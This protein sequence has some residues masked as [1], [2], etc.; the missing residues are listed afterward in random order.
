[1]L[2]TQLGP[3]ASK[4]SS[5]VKRCRLGA[6][7]AKTGS[8]S[9]L[10]GRRG[11]VPALFRAAATRL[12][13][14]SRGPPPR[15]DRGPGRCEPPTNFGARSA[16]RGD[17]RLCRGR[18]GFRTMSSQGD[19]GS[20]SHDLLVV[21][22][23]VLGRLIAARWREVSV[24]VLASVAAEGAQPARERPPVLDCLTFRCPSHLPGAPGIQDR[25]RDGVAPQPRR[26]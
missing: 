11:S 7:M 19:A 24:C 25:G 9:V 3:K 5:P 23:G 22:P 16:L 17:A 26:P 1:M 6:R 20:A 4:A 15:S 8:V 18:S 14:G 12:S 21:G 10:S 13:V 2:C